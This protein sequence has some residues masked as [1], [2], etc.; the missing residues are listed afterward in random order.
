[1]STLSQILALLT[2]TLFGYIMYLETFATTSPPPPAY[3]K[4]RFNV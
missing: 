3:S 4:S 2:A 1:M